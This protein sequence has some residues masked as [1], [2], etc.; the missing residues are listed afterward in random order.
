MK[1]I[2]LHQYFYTP[3]MIGVAGIRSYEFGRRLA[4]AG[5][6]VEMVTSATSPPPDA[7]NGWYETEEAGIHVHWL[8]V[9]YSNKIS[10]RKRIA[11]F[12]RFAWKS[13]WK[14]VRLEGD[15]IFATSGPLTI[16]LP[17]VFAALVKRKPLVF[18]V[19]DLWPEGAIQ[20][21]L[22][23]NPLARFGCRALERITYRFS[24][25]IVALSPGMKAGVVST[26]VPAEKVSV[27]PNASDLDFFDP[28]ATGG[29]MREKFGL[30]G[31]FSLAYFG[32][33]GM[34]NGLGYVLDA[35]AVLKRRGVRDV[36]FL[37]HGDGMRRADLEERARTEQLD[38]VVFSDPVEAKSE[39]A[40]VMAAVDVCM[41]IYANYPVLATCSPNKLFDTFAAAK[42]AL[43]NM[44]GPLQSLLEDNRCGVFVDP[45]S[46][47]DFA[48]KVVEL[49][50]KAPEEL[51]EMG[52][53]GR[54]LGERIF[55]RDKL[56]RKLNLI[57]ESVA[58]TGK[59]P[60]PPLEDDWK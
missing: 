8:P 18:E 29:R 56:A 46:P 40:E 6:R 43:T 35:A 45:G 7:P 44:P 34:A 30:D 57:L 22:L 1:I 60:R 50:E 2:Y 32:T 10:F 13:G 55:D 3:N 59:G 49:K 37:L 23:R 26:G 19:R 58:E 31:K 36:L 53:N 21:G 52:K 20:L 33:M 54:A 5:H 39:V 42:P 17:A 11:A 14:A 41:T 15:V 9:P 12:L 25:H 4:A 47:E 48:D 24:R 27:I 38:N 16:A 28:G 51:A